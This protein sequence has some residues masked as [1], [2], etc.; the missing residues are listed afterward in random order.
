MCEC[1]YNREGIDGDEGYRPDSRDSAFNNSPIVALI[2]RGY[3]C[4]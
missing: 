1:M 4:L 2:H 3:P